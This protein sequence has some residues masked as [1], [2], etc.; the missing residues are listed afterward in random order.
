MVR[1]C[2]RFTDGIATET[3]I[4]TAQDM[5]QSLVM[6]SK[7]LNQYLMKIGNKDNLSHG[8]K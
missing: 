6:F 5:Q 2:I 8:S 4:E 3:V 1:Y 7:I